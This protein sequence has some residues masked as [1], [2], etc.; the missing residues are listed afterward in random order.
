VNV[1]LDS[2]WVRTTYIYYGRTRF[3]D[4]GLGM[5]R[6]LG[7]LSDVFMLRYYVIWAREGVA[8]ALLLSVSRFE[9]GLGSG[10]HMES[11]SPED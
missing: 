5:E 7:F 9:V 8:I 11:T 1:Y 6:N 2:E 3:L 10:M 4:D